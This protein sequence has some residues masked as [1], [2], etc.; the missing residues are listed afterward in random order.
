M[1]G[2]CD[3]CDYMQKISQLEQQLSLLQQERER[4]LM[5]RAVVAMI[6]SHGSEQLDAER[7]LKGFGI[8]FHG[9]RFVL[10]AFS[11]HFTE[12]GTKD[13]GPVWESL[14]STF[15]AT[16]SKY[17]REGFQDFPAFITA[18]FNGCIFGLA[19]LPDSLPNEEYRAVFTT[20]CRIINDQLEAAEGFRFQVFLSSIGFGREAM[21]DLRKEVDVMRDYWEIVGDNLPEVLSYCD[22]TSNAQG[23]RRPADSRE[24]N[25]QFSDYINRGD[26]EKAKGFFRERIMR[27]VGGGMYSA[28]TIR[29]RIAG[30]L[31]YV[32]QTLSR[33]SQ[34]L[35]MEQ[36]FDEIHADE[37]LLSAETLDDIA[38]RMDIILDAMQSHWQSG[39]T[40]TQALA[41]NA[42]TFID[43]NYGNCDLNVNMVAES[44]GVSPSHLTRVFRSCYQMRVLEYIQQVRLLAAKRLLGKGL[45]LR[46]ISAQV[47]YGAQINL[48]RAFKRMEGVT[49]GQL[50]QEME[51]KNEIE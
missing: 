33:A 43:D 37:L 36:V 18:N 24:A 26:F 22:V 3:H 13:D 44:L 49:P 1:A 48:L 34:S 10:C 7:H 50:V 32:T 4:F 51:R 40:A 6:S 16:L 17:I 47:G 19:N 39:T 38:Q 27:D 29:F 41:R 30:M 42:R 9:N 35:G 20:R 23:E 21:A 28:T 14:N 45:T 25:E 15:Y 12:P 11:D 5:E 46:E 31:D 2:T 8:T